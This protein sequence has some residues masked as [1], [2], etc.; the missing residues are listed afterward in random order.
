MPA[1]PDFVKVSSDQFMARF[2]LPCHSR[3]IFLKV[4]VSVLGEDDVDC[5]VIIAAGKSEM[6]IPH[7]VPSM[8]RPT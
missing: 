6:V 4:E 5:D 8:K 2:D 7:L 1:G 3:E